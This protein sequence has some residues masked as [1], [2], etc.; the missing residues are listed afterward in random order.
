MIPTRDFGRALS[1]TRRNA[2]LFQGDA[3]RAEFTLTV[4]E[5]KE[6]S[7]LFLSPTLPLLNTVAGSVF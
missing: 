3:R 2:R 1:L 6:Q 7:S 5:T 4:R